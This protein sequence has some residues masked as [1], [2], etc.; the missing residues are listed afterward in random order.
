MKLKSTKMY[1][2]NNIYAKKVMEENIR[3]KYME[4]IE[5]QGNCTL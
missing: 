4:M 3:K 2:K 5:E 1:T